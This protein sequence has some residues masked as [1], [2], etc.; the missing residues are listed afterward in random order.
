MSAMEGR[1]CLVTGTTS[2]IGKITALEMARMGATVVMV[3]RDPGRGEAALSEIRAAS[4][5]GSV[6]LLLADLASLRQVRRLAEEFQAS[7]QHLHVMINNAGTLFPARATTEDGLDTTFAVNHLASFLLTNLLLGSIK[8]STPA[9]I[10]NV[11]STSHKFGA[12]D[13]AVIQGRRR[14]RRRFSGWKAYSHSELANVLFTYEL[15]RR[16]GGTGV[17][18]NCL[19]PGMVAGTNLASSSRGVLGFVINRYRSSLERFFLNL[20]CTPLLTPEQ[21]ARTSIYLASSPEVEGIS[22]KYFAKGI[23]VRSSRKSYDRSL[24]QRLWR[25]DAEL[26]GL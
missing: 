11:A 5:N 23:E 1:I 15:A 26:V 4:G 7:Y 18:A 10:V 19:H 20:P 6:H 21:G 17:T 22:G 8:A 3:A 24:A 14:W 9:R 25:M 13:L 2:G 12:I 16:L